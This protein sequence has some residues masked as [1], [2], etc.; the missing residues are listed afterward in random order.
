VAARIC[1]SD[2]PSCAPWLWP[3]L[4]SLDAPLVAVLWQALFARAFH[5]SSG[6]WTAVLLMLAVWLIY[7]ADRLL[8]AWRGS[9]STAR[10]QFYRRH[11]RVVVP[12]WTVVLAI[13]GWLASM[14]LSPM[15]FHRGMVL[16]AAVTVYFVVVHLAPER[17]RRVWPKEAAVAILFALG[18]TLAAWTRVHSAGDAASILIFSCLCWINC[19]AIEKWEHSE[20]WEHREVPGW[21]IGFAAAMVGAAALLLPLLHRPVL[22]E[23]ETASAFAFVLLDRGRWRFSIDA[24]RVLADV[25]LLTPLV[26]LPLFGV[27]V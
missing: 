1:S 20:K 10:H 26:F 15:L 13:T 14:H 6:A 9:G 11:W 18:A 25:A 23:A 27:L 2:A 21:P 7:A 22:G 24:L 5:A 17:L 8:D 12:V 16:S 3:N 4:L 19:V